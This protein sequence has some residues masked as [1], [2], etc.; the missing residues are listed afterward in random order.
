MRDAASLSDPA[1]N[2]YCFLDAV[3]N[4]DPTDLYIYQLPLGIGLPQNANPLCSPCS[5]SVLGVY[6]KALSDPAQADSLAGLKETYD[7]AIA[8][9][10]KSCGSTYATAIATSGVVALQPYSPLWATGAVMLLGYTLL[11]SS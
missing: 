8:L 11:V 2:T 5:G 7:P 6:A 10:I 4:T 3:R 1:T 9:I